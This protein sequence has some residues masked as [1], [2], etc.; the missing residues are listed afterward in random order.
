MA[1]RKPAS[2]SAIARGSWTWSRCVAPGSTNGSRVRQP[3]D[4]EVL[5]LAVHLRLS[6]PRITSAGWTMRAAASE[7][8][9]HAITAGS[10]WPKNCPGVGHGLLEGTRERGLEAG[11]VARAADAAQEDVDGRREVARLVVPERRPEDRRPPSSCCRGLGAPGFAASSS[12][13][14]CT[15]SGASSA[16][17]SAMQAPEEWPTTWAPSI[18]RWAIERPAVLGLPI[19]AE[20]SLDPAAARVAGPAMAD[21]PVAGERRLVHQRR[22][23]IGADT[24]VDEQDGL[25]GA[26][27]LVLELE[28]V[29]G[30]PAHVSKSR[31]RPARGRS[32]RS[33]SAPRSSRRCG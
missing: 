4:E 16:S 6:P 31:S 10:S 5:P 18:P 7:P 27:V 1:E 33:A 17:W 2:A 20:R 11:A 13:S 32:P 26:A 15:A 3:A 19:D 23:E 14:D 24:G 22:E 12:A 29:D 8:S 21:E 30:R 28:T 25:P 9:D